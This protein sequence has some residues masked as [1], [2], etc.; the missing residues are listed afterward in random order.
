MAPG[1]FA[2]PRQ[3]FMT[4]PQYRIYMRKRRARIKANGICP[5][6]EK[7]YAAPGH[8]CCDVCLKYRRVR[9][10]K[11][12]GSK[13]PEAKFTWEQIVRKVLGPKKMARL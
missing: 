5:S 12:T 13:K 11:R 4:R 2:A 1:S 6:C 3:N 9:E 8:I 7:R 10:R